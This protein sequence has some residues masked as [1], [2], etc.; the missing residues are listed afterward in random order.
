MNR[1]LRIVLVVSVGLSPAAAFAQATNPLWHEAKIKN[2]LPHM[3][4]PEVEDLLTRTDMVIIPIGAIEQHARHLPIG[5]DFINGVERAKLVAQQTDVLVAPILL[6]GN[7][8]YHMEFAGTI[9]LPAET[10]Q[11][12]YFEACQSLLAHGFRRFLLLNSHGGN[13]AITRYLV[14]RINQETAG[15]AV[16]LGE[17]ASPFMTR[18]ARGAAEPPAPA[19]TGVPVFD[20]H[21]G[22]G[23]TADGLYLFPSLVDVSKAQTA[24]LTMPAHLEQMVPDVLSGDRTTT[25]VFLAEG[26][27]AKQTGKGTSAAEMSTTGQWGLRDPREATAE[28]GRRSA[29][30]WV[31]AAVQFIERWKALRPMTRA[32]ASAAAPASAVPAASSSAGVVQPAGSPGGARRVIQP[33]R[34]PAT[35]LPYSPGILVDGTLYISGQLGRDPAT[36]KLVPGG[37]EAETRQAIANI[38]EVLKAAGMDLAD[39]VSVTVFITSFD[40]FP[41]FN[42]VYREHFATNPPARATV[43]VAGLNLGATIEIQMIAARPRDD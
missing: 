15:I 41:A 35:G 4:S 16:D 37:I 5:T 33:A 13:Q 42:Q 17:A 30:R 18:G 14:D 32:G 9:T 36:A 2:Y 1:L 34:F 31:N 40:D 43:Q 22:V 19:A 27:K 21:G 7:S 26:L 24:T 3:T 6:P 8:P 10:I 39:V 38:R 20:R 11:R 12:V 29:E 28:Q 25:L 23:E